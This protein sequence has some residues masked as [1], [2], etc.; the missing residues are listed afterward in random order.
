MSD[1]FDEVFGFVA[2]EDAQRLLDVG[3]RVTA[4]V[5]VL[6]DPDAGPMVQSWAQTRLGEVL[7]EQRLEVLTW[8]DREPRLATMLDV[9]DNFR[10][11]F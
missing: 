11:I 6:D 7:P 2:L 3:D 4:V 10:W 1:A 9:M 8:Q 5:A